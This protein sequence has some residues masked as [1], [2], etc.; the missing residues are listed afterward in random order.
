MRSF[1]CVFIG[2][3]SA[4][5]GWHGPSW[6]FGVPYIRQNPLFGKGKTPSNK[7][8][9]ASSSA[10]PAL[11]SKK[12]FEKEYSAHPEDQK[13]ALIDEITAMSRRTGYPNPILRDKNLKQLKRIKALMDEGK[14]YE[15]IQK[16]EVPRSDPTGHDREKR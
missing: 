14:G 9:S 16:L 6:R 11:E 3:A 10:R 8:S 12:K 7:T 5:M 2:S 4:M 1:L 13:N 15:T